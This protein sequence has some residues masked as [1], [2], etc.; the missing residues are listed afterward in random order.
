[1]VIET[2]LH[3][4]ARSDKQ[5][6]ISGLLHCNTGTVLMTAGRTLFSPGLTDPHTWTFIRVSAINGYPHRRINTKNILVQY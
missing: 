6:I 2:S 4:D 1:L 5:T 3:Y